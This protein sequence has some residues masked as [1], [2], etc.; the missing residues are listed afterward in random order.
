MGAIYNLGTKKHH[1]KYLPKSERGEII[2]VYGLT[3]LGHGS[4]VSGIETTATFDRMK[5]EFVVNMPTWT[6]QKYWP[7]NIAEDGNHAVIFA[8]LMMDG[9]DRGVH[10]FVVPFRD[11][12]VWN[13]LGLCVCVWILM[14]GSGFSIAWRDDF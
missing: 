9:V 8:K 12:N 4:N 5:D 7:G 10:A 11:E 14:V 3:E 13:V 1:D 2:G 6:A